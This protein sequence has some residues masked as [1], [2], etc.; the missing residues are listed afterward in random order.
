MAY[1]EHHKDKGQHRRVFRTPEAAPE[2][3]ELEPSY[4]IYDGDEDEYD[5]YQDD[6][7]DAEDELSEE[8]RAQARRDHWR[9]LAGVG[10]FLAV[11]AGTAVIL[12]LI[13]LLVSLINWVHAD[14]TQTFTLWQTKI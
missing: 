11:V 3:E 9:V 8:E 1:F 13:A 14:I 12:V 5:I 4:Q 6:G 2:A 10:D 7:Y